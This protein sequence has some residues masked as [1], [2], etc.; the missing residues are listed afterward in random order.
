MGPEWI[1]VGIM[2]LVVALVVGLVVGLV[3]RLLQVTSKVLRGSSLMGA[4]LP[5]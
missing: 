2:V 3:V 1:I 4:I 5:W